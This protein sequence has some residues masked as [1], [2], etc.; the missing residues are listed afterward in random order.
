MNQ[1]WVVNPMAISA[2]VFVLRLGIVPAPSSAGVFGLAEQGRKHDRHAVHDGT[3]SIQDENGP[4]T[5]RSV[6]LI[7]A[8]S[9]FLS[10]R[11]DAAAADTAGRRIVVPANSSSPTGRRP[12]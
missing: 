7:L 12:R 8:E 5:R 11:P 10:I 3:S 1:S 9:D 4:V 6:R 2:R